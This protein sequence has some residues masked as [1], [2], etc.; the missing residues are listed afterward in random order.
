MSTRATR[1]GTCTRPLR[2]ALAALALLSL[3]A[4]CAQN[5]NFSDLPSLAK[6]PQRLLTKDEQKQAISELGQKDR[7]AAEQGAAQTTR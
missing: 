4:G 6:N 1:D 2:L 5:T 3:V 7:K